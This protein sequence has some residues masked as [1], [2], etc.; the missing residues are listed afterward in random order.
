MVFTRSM[1]LD[2]E[3]FRSSAP[4]AQPYSARISFE[5][6][7]LEKLKANDAAAFDEFV[8]KY[9]GDVFSLLYRL[10]ENADDAAELT[11]E[12]FLNAFRSMSKFRGESGLKTW[13]F[14]IAVNESRNRFR[15]WKRRK[16]DRTISLDATIGD[17]EMTL[18]DT[19]ADRGLS[20]EGEALARERRAALNSALLDLPI[21][22]RE[23]V[24]LC[25]IEGL[26]YDE[27]ALALDIGIGTVKSRISRGREELRRRLKDL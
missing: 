20:P 21:A 15:W 23:A 27:T 19:I 18:S 22:F 13:L 14:R 3:E 16:R 8:D 2:D 12:T 25:D 26:T 7:L 4:A 10:T 24:I 9:S 17:S 6:E 1:T 5:S 11:Q